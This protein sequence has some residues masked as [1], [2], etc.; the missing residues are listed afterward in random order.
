MPIT[1]DYGMVVGSMFWPCCCDM[2][3]M[4]F[5]KEFKDDAE[6]PDSLPEILSDLCSL[7]S[8]TSGPRIH[9]PGG[10][11]DNGD[12]DMD[13]EEHLDWLAEECPPVKSLTYYGGT[14]SLS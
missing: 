14:T 4:Q 10:H 11:E 2:C 9:I 1:L 12:F 8:G 13:L 6:V 7:C 3:G 5:D